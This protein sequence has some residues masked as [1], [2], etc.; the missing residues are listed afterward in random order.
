MI[1]VF[2]RQV[3]GIAFSL[4]G[5][6]P[7]ELGEITPEELLVMLK[8]ARERDEHQNYLANARTARIQA[9][10]ANIYRDTKK[11]P[12]PF[13]PKEFMPVYRE[14]KKPDQEQTPEEHL[15]MIKLANKTFNRGKT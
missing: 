11:H 15:E 7:H 12:E 14:E 9:L 8:A 3:Q 4:C 6:R 1:D 5:I 2:I 13:S 10:L